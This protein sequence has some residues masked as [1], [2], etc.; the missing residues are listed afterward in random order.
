MAIDIFNLY[1][2]TNDMKKIILLSLIL[3]SAR[4]CRPGDGHLNDDDKFS[5]NI[6]K[7]L[8]K[9]HHQNI[10][11][12]NLP[13]ITTIYRTIKYAFNDKAETISALNVSFN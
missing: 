5:T 13:S 4:K 11:L 6:T 12:Y 7:T 2:K 9:D 1:I 3:L 10:S 8:N